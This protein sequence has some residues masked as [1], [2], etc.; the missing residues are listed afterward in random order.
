[1]KFNVVIAA[2]M[3][4]R[5]DLAAYLGEKCHGRVSLGGNSAAARAVE[6]C[7]KGIA[8][9]C[10][11]T[12]TCTDGYNFEKA[13]TRVVFPPGVEPPTDLPPW[14][15][16]LHID[17]T[18]IP[19]G[20]RVLEGLDPASTTFFASA[21]LYLMNPAEIARFITDSSPYTCQ[22]MVPFVRREDF[23]RAF[24]K[25]EKQFFKL[26]EGRFAFARVSMAET[27]V[28]R[29]CA[30]KVAR[31]S[32]LA[33]DPLEMAKTMGLKISMKYAIGRLSVADIEGFVDTHLEV[34]SKLVTSEVPTL[35]LSI[36]TVGR[37]KEIRHRMKG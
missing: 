4:M 27:G 23:E 2:N 10:G 19:G 36:N 16:I 7:W 25:M 11:G 13:A 32:E 15:E 1:M 21:D 3:P 8:M 26:A 20:E 31:M 35:T 34:N 18:D 6:S 12:G 22:I 28:A 33:E 30:A 14:V 17:I 9:A 5:D 24:G 29:R 37:M